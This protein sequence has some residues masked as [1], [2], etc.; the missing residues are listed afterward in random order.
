MDVIDRIVEVMVSKNLLVRSIKNM[1]SRYIISYYK[2][3]PKNAT[4]KF[5]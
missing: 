3:A 1:K 5:N 2:A 4:K